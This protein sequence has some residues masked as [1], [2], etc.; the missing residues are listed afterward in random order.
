MMF[1]QM[2]HPALT[3]LAVC[4]FSLSSACGPVP[5]RPEPD[6][7]YWPL[8]P[9]RPR[10]Q[11]IQSIY[12]EDDIGRVYSFKEKLFGKEYIDTMSRPYGVSVRHKKMLVTD[13]VM[14]SV[15]LFDLGAKRLTLLGGEG[16]LHMPSAAVSDREGNIYVADVDA[17]K[18]AV[19]TPQGKYRTAFFLQDCRPV[20][21]AINEAL[22]RLY[23]VNRTRH[24]V[25]VL[26][27][28]GDLLFSFGG[29]GTAPG[30]FNLPLN[31]ALDA[32]GDVYVLDSGN[33]RVQMFDQDGRFL[34]K[35]GSVGDR[36]GLF[37][38]PKGIAV[39]SDGHIFVTDA[40]F[41]NFQI[42]DN[43]GNLLMFV[44]K[45]GSGPGELLVPSG[46]SIDEDDRIYIVD[47]FNKRVEVFQYL[48]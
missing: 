40:A 9:E 39:D 20:A 22:G 12:S 30:K 25:L 7:L 31:V 2:K 15:L 24:M 28:N 48:K 19:Y 34:N 46:I 17:E 6:S 14:R 35:F 10:I 16:A 18:I 45:L 37:A 44:G 11:Y 29:Q 23:V 43:E 1:S 33:F 8:P 4:L 27:L 42:F 36:A 38:N 32:T 21:L 47:Q 41:N 26:N 5:G 3:G 13:I